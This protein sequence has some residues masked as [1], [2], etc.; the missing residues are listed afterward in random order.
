G[1][2]SAS[3]ASLRSLRSLR[4]A[5]STELWPTGRA[6]S[7]AAVLLLGEKLARA[8]FRRDS[9]SGGPG[10][11]KSGRRRARQEARIPGMAQTRGRRTTTRT[12]TTTV[13]PMKPAEPVEA[14]EP[15]GP[16]GA[17]TPRRLGSRGTAVAVGAGVLVVLALRL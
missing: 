11:R 4:S 2:S 9:A 8:L 1:S 14:T 13:E 17:P 7:A 15:I 6:G 10:G 3:L 16:S 5:D 12:S